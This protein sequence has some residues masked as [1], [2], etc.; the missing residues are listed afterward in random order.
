MLTLY[1]A[2]DAE[3]R[4]MLAAKLP[5]GGYIVIEKNESATRGDAGA[6]V[7]FLT[8]LDHDAEITVSGGVGYAFRDADG[9]EA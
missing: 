9:G 1:R 6:P 2:T 8:V 4:K 5:S 7:A 3:G